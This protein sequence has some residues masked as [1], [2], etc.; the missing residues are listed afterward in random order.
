MQDN[1]ACHKAKI[2]VT[3]F[4]EENAIV[5]DWPAQS[6]NLN[7]IENV[8]KILG[9]RSKARNPKQPNSCGLHLRKHG[10]RYLCKIPND[11]LMQ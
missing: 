1:A 10:I 9:E 3:F 5:I 8:C 11:F 6:L 4:N 2:V 7:P